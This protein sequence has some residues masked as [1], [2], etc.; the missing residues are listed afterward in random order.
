[1]ASKAVGPVP[2][3]S[4]PLVTQEDIQAALATPLSSLPCTVA[5]IQA[6]IPGFTPNPSNVSIPVWTNQTYISGW[7][8]GTDFIPYITSV[9]YDYDRKLQQTIFVGLGTSVG[10]GSY[11]QR[12]DC[13]L[14]ASQTDIPQYYWANSQWVATCC[15]GNIP[16]VGLPRPDWLSADGGIVV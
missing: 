7:T 3:Y 14:S 6:I 2:G 1:V 8:I 16:G 15:D 5:D 4:N 13:C 9:Y 10:L 12:Q 11:Y